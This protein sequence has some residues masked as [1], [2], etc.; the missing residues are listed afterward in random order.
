[1]AKRRQPVG[2]AAVIA[3]VTLM[4]GVHTVGSA[5]TADPPPKQALA[6][7]ARPGSDTVI[8]VIDGESFDVRRGK[9]TVRIRLLNVDAPE[10]AA[11]GRPAAC[12]AADA[13][14]WLTRRLSAGTPVTIT[15]DSAGRRTSRTENGARTLFQ[16]V[17]RQAVGSQV[18]HPRLKVAA[19]L[20]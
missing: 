12:G 20:G 2:V 9:E 7:R 6:A 15:Y 10:I 4:L 14:A 17:F 13:T 16:Q 8:R 5:V 19:L 11:D 3:A 18:T 1:M